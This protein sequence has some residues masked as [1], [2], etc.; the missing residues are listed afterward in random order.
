MRR[1]T[2][3][4]I[5]Y[6]ILF[7]GI[8]TAGCGPKSAPTPADT[9]SVPPVASE[10]PGSE[11]AANTNVKSWSSGQ[12]LPPGARAPRP[13]PPVGTPPE[14]TGIA[15]V[16]CQEL[17]GGYMSSKYFEKVVQVEGVTIAQTK[18]VSPGQA[19]TIAMAGVPMPFSTDLFNVVGIPA[20]GE[21]EK[22]KA[23][24]P[25]RKVRMVGFVHSTASE[26]GMLNCTVTDLGAGSEPTPVRMADEVTAE[27]A[28]DE[29][30]AR[31]KYGLSDDVPAVM[32]LRGKVTESATNGDT[33]TVRVDGTNGFSVSF[34]M[35]VTKYTKPPE[36][37]KTVTVVGL[38]EGYDAK[39]KTLKLRFTTVIPY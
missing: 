17:Q 29:V 38:F 24:V 37:S 14:V 12:P 2:L 28:K 31:K 39:S 21:M 6:V 25:G 7:G 34:E 35:K 4:L 30:A 5:H 23:L 33:G 26:L 11:P 3:N 8:V 16:I 36:I 22:F 13:K 9:A 15:E 10:P 19:F 20:A 1:P 27:F 32:L 18:K